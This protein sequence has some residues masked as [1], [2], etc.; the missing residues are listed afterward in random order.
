MTASSTPSGPSANPV[1][2]LLPA[3][4]VVTDGRIVVGGVALA[5]IAGRFGTPAYVLDV[6]T[7]RARAS[8]MR[9]GLALR[10]PRSEVLFASKSLPALAMYELAAAE[11]LSVDVA[12]DGEL[13]LALAAGVEPSRLYFHGNAKTE[14]ELRLAVDRG[15]GTVI[16]DNADELERLLH[17]ARTD[18]PQDVLVRLRPDVLAPTHPSQ[19]TGGPS[20]KFGVPLDQAVALMGRIE[21]APNLALRGVHVHIGSQILE[22][23]PFA[24]AVRRLAAVGEYE[25]YDVGGGLGVRYTLGEEPPTI[26]EYLD[27]VTAAAREALPPGA[28]LLVEPGRSLVAPAGLTL[29]RVV[30]VKRTGRTFV[31]VDGGMADNLD[32]ALTGQRYEAIVDGRAGAAPGT[33]CTLV[34]RQCESGDTLIDGARLA[35]PEVGDLLALLVTGAYAYTMANNYN[36]S[37]LPPLVLVENGQAYEAARRQTFEDVVA[38]QRRL[39]LG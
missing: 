7:F 24:E 35:T 23:A 34:G 19:A 9:E 5:E 27:A 33:T 12:G 14:A 2:A 3:S 6:A 15:V 16:V 20:S 25:V 4:A 1:V 30:G 17:L 39:R 8:A 10:W 31:A 38:L 29:Y 28:K 32:V 13:R 21:D 26:D 37:Y 11:G 22:T 18:A 36:G